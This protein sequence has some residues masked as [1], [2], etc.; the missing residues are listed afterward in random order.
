[1]KKWLLSAALAVI[2]SPCFADISQFGKYYEQIVEVVYEHDS[3]ITLNNN[4]FGPVEAR[5]KPLHYDS[6]APLSSLPGLTE[7]DV[8]LFSRE[9]FG[10]QIWGI[11]KECAKIAGQNL[12]VAKSMH[13]ISDLFEAQGPGSSVEKTFPVK[14]VKYKVADDTDDGCELSTQVVVEVRLRDK[15]A[16]FLYAEGSQLE[17]T[18]EKSCKEQFPIPQYPSFRVGD[19]AC[20][21]Y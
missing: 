2:A 18:F 1:M 7:D 15:R 16:L 8:Q 17:E 10:N 11:T 19:Y 21:S 9:R 12:Q 5:L 14:V 4:E 3:T 20:Q 6:L 13:Y